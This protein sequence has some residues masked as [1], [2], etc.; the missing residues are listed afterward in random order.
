MV[1]SFVVGPR[2]EAM[3]A[4]DLGIFLSNPRHRADILAR[5]ELDAKSI[6]PIY[7]GHGSLCLTSLL[8]GHP[9]G[10]RHVQS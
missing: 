1:L 6:P 2:H 3:D 7:H 4:N 10:T 9:V 8:A 5:P